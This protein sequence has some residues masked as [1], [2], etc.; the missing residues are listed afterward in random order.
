MTKTAA[1]ILTLLVLFAGCLRDSMNSAV[2]AKENT[3]DDYF[4]SGE[5]DLAIKNWKEVLE[6]REKQQVYE[7]LISAF[8]LKNQLDTAEYYANKG[9][10]SFPNNVNLIFNL[11][12]IKFF[13]EEYKS[14]QEQLDL[15]LE[16]NEYYSNAHYLKGLIF[17]KNG[18][19]VRAKKEYVTEI[20]I[21]PGSKRAWRKLKEMSNEAQK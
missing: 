19:K 2:K 11:A 10:T 20:N 1:V 8:I 18:D 3:G 4:S 17:E 9:L 6:Y 16:I 5:L 12:L 14:A 15:L 13:K 7:K 21:N